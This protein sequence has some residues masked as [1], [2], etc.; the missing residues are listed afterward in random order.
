MS[1]QVPGWAFAKLSMK[2]WS[3]S[4]HD[5]SEKKKEST[6]AKIQLSFEGQTTLKTVSIVK[7]NTFNPDFVMPRD[8]V[9]IR[10]QGHGKLE[11]SFNCYR[12]LF[13]MNNMKKLTT[14]VPKNP[15]LYNKKL[16]PWMKKMHIESWKRARAFKPEIVI[17]RADSL[18][19]YYL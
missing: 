16:K 18:P 3:V 9:W 12:S 8:D 14:F 2:C 6:K 10:V 5:G 19:G 11:I 7:D 1:D 4:E 13:S 15:A 17:T